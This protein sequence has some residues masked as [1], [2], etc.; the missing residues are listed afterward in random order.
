MFGKSLLWKGASV[1]CG[2]TVHPMIYSRGGGGRKRE[3]L[4]WKPIKMSTSSRRLTKNELTMKGRVQLVLINFQQTP[5][6]VN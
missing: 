2:M 3:N 4:E 5:T 1:S 6:D